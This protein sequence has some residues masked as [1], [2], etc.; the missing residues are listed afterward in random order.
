MAPSLIAFDLWMNANT[1]ATAA[2]KK[3]QQAALAYASGHAPPPSE[4]DLKDAFMKRLAATR[5]FESVLREQERIA[6][7]LQA[8]RTAA[9]QSRA[10]SG[11]S[12]C[13]AG[14]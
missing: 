9:A 14:E 3:V 5:A 12:S 11:A 2:E 8:S 6:R 13:V 4:D 1:E 10:A 7:E